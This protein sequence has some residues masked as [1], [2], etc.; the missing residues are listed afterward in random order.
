MPDSD[1]PAPD[2]PAYVVAHCEGRRCAEVLDF[3]DQTEVAPTEAGAVAALEH[4][5]AQFRAG[6]AVGRLVL[7]ERRT[8]A[9]VAERR[10][11]P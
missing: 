2:P 5:A 3:A 10:V 6:G 8:G 1:S 7:R 9:V 4:L 11:W